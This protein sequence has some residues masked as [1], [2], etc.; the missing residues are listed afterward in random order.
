[1]GVVVGAEVGAGVGVAGC[2][3]DEVGVWVGTVTATTGVAGVGAGVFKGG[4]GEGGGSWGK[5]ES[6]PHPVAISPRSKRIS[7]AA[8]KF[9]F[10]LILIPLRS[11]AANHLLCL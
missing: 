3:P 2:V 10:L 7:T 8:G 11:N 5:L 4:L 1:M 9:S 6:S